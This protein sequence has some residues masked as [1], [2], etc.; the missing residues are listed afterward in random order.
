MVDRPSSGPPLPAWYR[1]HG[2]GPIGQGGARCRPV[3]GGSGTH[4]QPGA[5][6]GWRS[7]RD[8]EGDGR[9]RLQWAPAVPATSGARLPVVPHVAADPEGERLQ[10]TVGVAAHRRR[11]LEPRARGALHAP[12]PPPPSPDP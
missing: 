12:P 7:G 10:A 9:P 1:A 5:P 3:S 2:A 11:A 4:A 6:G 8:L